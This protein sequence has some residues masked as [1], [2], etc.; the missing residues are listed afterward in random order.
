M[1][2]Y[3]GHDGFVCASLDP[4][5]R[6]PTQLKHSYTPPQSPALSGVFYLRP[7]YENGTAAKTE[8]WVAAE[9][10]PLWADDEARNAALTYESECDDLATQAKRARARPP[11]ET[12]RQRGP[13]T[14]FGKDAAHEKPESD[15]VRR[16]QKC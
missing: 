13:S 8:K 16:E 1:A 15:E 14:E 9:V 4:N 3:E 12:A 6:R 7:R 10:E 11:G 5:A 2:R